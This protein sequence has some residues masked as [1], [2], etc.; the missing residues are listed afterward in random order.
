M[1]LQ[2][3]GAN[4]Q[5]TGSR[6]LV[7]AAGLR[8]MIDC[9]MFQERPFLNRNWEACPVPPESIDVLLLTH[10]HL[11]HVGLLPRLV[12]QG[13]TGKVSAVEPSVDLAEVILLDAA[14]IQEED[15]AY[16]KRRHKKEGRR[17]K[18]PEEPL[19]TAEDAEK[20]LPLFRGVQYNEAVQLS[21]HVQAVFHQAGHI[22]GS[23]SIELQVNEHGKSRTILFSGDVGQ[24]NKP[25]IEDPALA[26]QADY[27]VVESTYGD[28]NHPPAQQVDLDLERIVRE[29][30][31]RGGNVVIPT[32]AMERAQELMF[33]ISKLVHDD[34]IPDLKVFLD[35]PM[36]IN[37]TKIF[38]QYRHYMDDDTRKLFEQNTPPLQFPG[39]HLTRTVEASKAIAY[40]RMPCI[41]MASSG[42]CTG[43]RI[44]HHLRHNITREESTIVFVG[45]QATRTLGRQ[46]LNGDREVRI[47]G[48]FWPVRARIEQISGLSAHGDKDD[49]L[50][51]LSGIKQPPRTLFLTHGEEQASLAFADTIQRTLGWRTSVPE[52]Q[53]VVELD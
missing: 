14:K 49:L 34:R 12:M 28:R 38:K 15:A 13:F 32:F 26:P 10:A 3:L 44:K 37:V 33:H 51:W 30:A 1:R 43:G 22:L 25:L 40:E 41:I 27:V 5:V 11:D 20:A 52:Y 23:A 53:E 18:Y 36:A 9:G 8:V 4:R 7:E 16:K 46:I 35:S 42:M 50:H 45:Y 47:H 17:G 19:Y 39:L 29:T 6:Y 2:F 48:R 31:N 24:W 21:P